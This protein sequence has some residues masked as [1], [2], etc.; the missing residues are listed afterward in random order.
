M[1]QHYQIKFLD[2]SKETLNPQELADVINQTHTLKH[3]RGNFLDY[4]IE[5][6]LIIKVILESYFLKKNSKLRKVLRI[7]LLNKMSLNQ[8]IGILLAII[9]E[10]KELK[11][12]DQRPLKGYLN[13]L[14]KERNKWAHGVIRFNEEKQ[15]EKRK[16]QSYLNWIQEDG[17]EKE[18]KLIDSY[19]DDL[20]NK[21]SENRDFLVKILV[22]RKLL[23]KQYLFKK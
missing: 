8:K 10:K 2:K 1:A 14:R 5:I 21:F 13:S 16:F 23:P 3:I 15:G 9:N 20:T 12:K 7:N 11:K 22:K 4:I 17:S 19:F 18:T 6:E